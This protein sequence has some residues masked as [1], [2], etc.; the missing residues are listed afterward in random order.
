ME[1]AYHW[2]L[3]SF[4]NTC[5]IIGLESQLHDGFPATVDGQKSFLADVIAV[6]QEAPNHEGTS[7]F[8]W[9][10]EWIAAPSYGSAWENLALF[11]FQGEVLASIGYLIRLSTRSLRNPD[12]RHSGSNTTIHRNHH[13]TST[14][15]EGGVVGEVCGESRRIEILQFQSLFVRFIHG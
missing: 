9:T 5:N 8:Y 13:P 11:D 4:D 10:P 14:L 2:T 1:S 6:V 15:M 3:D 12:R 7:F